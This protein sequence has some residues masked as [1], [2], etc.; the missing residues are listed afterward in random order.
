MAPKCRRTGIGSTGIEVV[1]AQNISWSARSAFTDITHGTCVSVLAGAKHE[2]YF[3]AATL[4]VRGSALI[5]VFTIE[6]GSGYASPI[7]TNII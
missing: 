3:T 7:G 4:A 5:V 1:T 2:N 6:F